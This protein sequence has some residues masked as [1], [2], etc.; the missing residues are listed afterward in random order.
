MCLA[1]HWHVANSGD[2]VIYIGDRPK[3][4]IEMAN[5]NNAKGSSAAADSK[6][7]AWYAADSMPKSVGKCPTDVA[8]VIRSYITLQG[9][10]SNMLSDF[11]NADWRWE[12]MADAILASQLHGIGPTHASLKLACM[13]AGES[14]RSR[15]Q[16][17]EQWIASFGA[18]KPTVSD[19]HCV[20][21]Y[22]ACRMA[23]WLSINAP[24]ACPY[25]VLPDNG[26][27]TS[28]GKEKRKV[29]VTRLA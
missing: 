26:T 7:I 22:D 2:H 23:A 18:G 24:H 10:D 25:T 9:Y 3:A 13:N 6:A 27:S 12:D 19:A 11:R 21:I 16:R 8:A 29:S 5:E 14:L 4:Y 1:E 17:K 15:Y 20:S 28:K